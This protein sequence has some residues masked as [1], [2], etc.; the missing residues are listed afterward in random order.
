MINKARMWSF[1]AHQFVTLNIEI[2]K[3]TNLG[4]KYFKK[5]KEEN[6]EFAYRYNENTQ[7]GEAFISI[8]SIKALFNVDIKEN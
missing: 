3:L 4:F 7:R 5:V 2:S 8:K 6:T 1:N